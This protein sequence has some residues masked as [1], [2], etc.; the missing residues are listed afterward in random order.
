M[1]TTKTII[2]LSAVILASF[3]GQK[4]YSWCFMLPNSVTFGSSTDALTAGT[5]ESIK[6]APEVQDLMDGNVIIANLYSVDAFKVTFH[7]DQNRLPFNV[8]VPRG[9]AIGINNAKDQYFLI[10]VDPIAIGTLLNPSTDLWAK[11]NWPYWYTNMISEVR[12]GNLGGYVRVTAAAVNDLPRNPVGV[13]LSDIVRLGSEFY[14]TTQQL[15]NGGSEA[16]FSTDIFEDVPAVAECVED[17]DVDGGNSRPV[18][19][20]WTLKR[21]F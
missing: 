13:S 2:V 11:G 12:N 17:C 15:P 19:V 8:S 4:A 21:N 6:G 5:A 18:V 20:T 9:H 14:A 3:I 7:Y 1:R 16:P 10:K